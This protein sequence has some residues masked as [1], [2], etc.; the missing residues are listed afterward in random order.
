MKHRIPILVLFL[1]LSFLILSPP[2]SFS[3]SVDEIVQMDIQQLMKMD[4]VVTS[5]SKRP[6]KVHQT[7]SAIYV[8]TSEDIRRT[9]ATNI[10]EALRTVP[11]VLVSKINQ[12][13]YAVSVRGFNRRF[14]DKL[15]VLIDGRSVYTPTNSGVFWIGQ[16]MY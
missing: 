6:Q 7:A 1:V 3:Q 14:S 16:D 10:M 4:V 8:V 13:Q 9:G 5:A 12:N 2:S 11:G 15:L